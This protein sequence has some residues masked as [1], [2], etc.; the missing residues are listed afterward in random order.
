MRNKLQQRQNNGNPIRVGLIGAGAMGIGIAW[1]IGHTPGME[2]V[3]IADIN[4]AAALKATRVAGKIAKIIDNPQHL[5]SRRKNETLVVTDPLTLLKSDNE[6][7][8]DVLVE[9]SN[10]IGPA[11]CYCFAAIDRGAHVVLMNAEVDLA[12]GPLLNHEAQRKGVIVTSDAGDQHGVLMTMIEEIQL[13][14]FRIVQAGNIKGFLNRYATANSLIE[15]AKKRHL[16]PIQCCAYTDGTKL[17]IEMCCIANGVGL[18]PFVQGMEGP[19]THHVTSVLHMF[20]FDAY[21]N[22]G[23][24][25]YILGAEPGGGV[26]VVGYCDDPVQIEYL[27]YY[28][29][30][31]PPY[32]LFYRPYHLCHLETTRAIAKAALYGEAILTPRFGRMTDTYTFAKTNLKAGH[33]FPHAI[34]SD[35]L[36]GLADA[37]HKAD[38]KGLVPI[39]LLEGEAGHASKLVNAKQKDEPLY[40]NDIDFADTFLYRCFK[41]QE[42]LLTK[43]LAETVLGIS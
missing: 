36:Y 4:Q 15:E 7:E 32:Y 40:M 13:W 38:A 39:V 11:A 5:L 2:I 29:M 1:Q 25:D 17:N 23:R 35:E 20:D 18:I 30:G 21:G 12:L 8:L 16:S 37:C 10:T 3:F 28:K 26:Y 6:L 43:K 41:Q 33:T 34:G 22:Q 27:R 24:I 9:A 14:G 19:E 42:K 31:E